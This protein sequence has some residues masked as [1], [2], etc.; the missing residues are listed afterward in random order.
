M[1]RISLACPDNFNEN[2]ITYIHFDQTLPEHVQI[3][4][5]NHYF[6]MVMHVL[7]GT[8][9]GSTLASELADW[10]RN[11]APRMRASH[12]ELQQSG[13]LHTGKPLT[14]LPVIQDDANESYLIDIIE[15]EESWPVIQVHLPDEIS[16]QHLTMSVRA[17]AQYFLEK[18]DNFYRQLPLHI[19]TML[20]FYKQTMPCS[21]PESVGQAPIYAMNIAANLLSQTESGQE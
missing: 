6:S 16:V 14:L 3:W 2:T 18:N 4:V 11:F 13:E 17:L 8:D 1:A 5:W 7:D 19:L 15:Q 20:R 21:I 9:E 12:S 10:A